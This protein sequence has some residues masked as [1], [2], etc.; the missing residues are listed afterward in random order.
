[1]RECFGASAKMVDLFVPFL[2]D[3]LSAKACRLETL[4]ILALILSKFDNI[5]SPLLEQI[6]SQ[7][8]HLFYQEPSQEEKDMHSRAAKVIGLALSHSV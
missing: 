8:S 3:K 1:M 7:V 2:L 4:D 6:T 5:P